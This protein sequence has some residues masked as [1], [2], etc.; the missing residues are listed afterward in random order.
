MARGTGRRRSDKQRR[1]LH[2]LFRSTGEGAVLGAGFGAL[3]SGRGSR[4]RGAKQDALI[5]AAL[6]AVIAIV[7]HIRR[8]RKKKRL[9][10]KKQLRNRR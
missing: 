6:G 9:L 2:A 1:F 8:N 10:K 5:S 7:S 4:I 3:L